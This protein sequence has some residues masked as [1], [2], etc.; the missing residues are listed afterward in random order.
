MEN[1]KNRL[2]KKVK[3]VRNFLRSPRGKKM[4]RIAIKVACT[5]GILYLTLVS[6]PVSA[7]GTFT[8]ISLK[9]RRLYQE[10][11]KAELPEKYAI[12]TAFMLQARFNIKGVRRCL[13]V[14]LYGFKF[15]YPV[16]DIAGYVGIMIH[17]NGLMADIIG[18][19]VCNMKTWDG[20][21]TLCMGM[22]H[23]SLSTG[24]VL[25][26]VAEQAGG[27]KDYLKQPYPFSWGY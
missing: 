5:G 19:L 8:S 16:Y 7:V 15:R 14:M 20:M 23:T 3:K 18:L 6:R 22:S 4:T 17:L 25:A 24:F 1:I 26:E 21:T 12:K 13:R 27:L 11:V 10:V 2:K 9:T